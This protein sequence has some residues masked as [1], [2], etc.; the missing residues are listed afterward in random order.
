MNKFS[1]EL[2]DLPFM[3]NKPISN[4]NV[5]VNACDKDDETDDGL[6]DYQNMENK[7]GEIK[8]NREFI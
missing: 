2:A 4:K 7:K 8:N 1:K 5:N 3:K 6:D